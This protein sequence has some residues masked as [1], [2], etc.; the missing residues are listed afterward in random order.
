VVSSQTFETLLTSP[1]HTPQTP[2]PPSTQASRRLHRTRQSLGSHRHDLLVALRVVNRIEKEVLEA[3]YENWLVDETQKCEVMGT[4]LAR[5][6]E[7]KDNKGKTAGKGVK[8][9]KAEGKVVEEW[10]KG[11]CGDCE[12][13]L[14]SVKGHRGLI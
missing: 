9:G 7:E 11:Y 2:L 10:V 12:R 13:A 4:I 14:G 1:Q 8:E 6:G 5:D 3:E